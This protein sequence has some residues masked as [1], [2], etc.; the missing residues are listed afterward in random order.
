MIDC[1]HQLSFIIKVFCAPD[2]L[3]DPVQE[4]RIKESDASIQNIVKSMVPA[5]LSMPMIAKL[6]IAV[7]LVVERK[8]SRSTL[9]HADQVLQIRRIPP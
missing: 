4:L 3:D 1:I 2:R 5:L 7:A 8:K 6:A 9:N